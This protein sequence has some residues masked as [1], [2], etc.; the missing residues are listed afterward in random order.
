[1][2]PVR[3]HCAHKKWLFPDGKENIDDAPLPKLI[4]SKK[5]NEGS[6]FQQSISVV[7]VLHC[8]YLYN[9]VITNLS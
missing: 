9:N 6:N 1:M 4:C 8:L 2:M 7:C 5:A 3:G